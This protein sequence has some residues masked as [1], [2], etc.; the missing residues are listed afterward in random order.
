M[1]N[2]FMHDA[3]IGAI[4]WNAPSFCASCVPPPREKPNGFG[5]PDQKISFTMKNPKKERSSAFT[6]YERYKM[7]TSV[8]Q[9]RELG[10]VKKDFFFSQN[11]SPGP[12]DRGLVE[13]DFLIT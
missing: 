13:V 12:D 9:A 6:K 8:G 7:A 4:L 2:V 10:A 11:C 1:L 3:S 5:D